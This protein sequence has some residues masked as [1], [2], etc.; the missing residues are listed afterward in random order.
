MTLVLGRTASAT[1]TS[2]SSIDLPAIDLESG[3]V[4]LLFVILGDGAQVS[5]ITD[6][7]G[8]VW[9]SRVA[10]DLG[11]LLDTEEWYAI[12]PPP[13]PISGNVITINFSNTTSFVTAEA[14]GVSG[15]NLES[16]F[17]LTAPITGTS[18]P[19]TVSTSVAHTMVVGAY[20]H[21]ITATPAP[22][23]GFIQIAGSDYLGVEYRIFDSIQ[24]DLLVDETDGLEDITTG[25]VDVLLAVGDVVF[26]ESVTKINL[27]GT[28]QFLVADFEADNFPIVEFSSDDD[29]NVLNEGSAYI[30]ETDFGDPTTRYRVTAIRPKISGDSVMFT[31]KDAEPLF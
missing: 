2:G 6:T 26:P 21:S 11:G 18:M 28:I 5:S 29:G 10:V 15:V 7:A 17:G 27:T 13:S 14:F 30:Y 9:S 12:A 24:N 4:V 3:T 25:I 20:R 1:A 16:V 8:L 23:A 19:L 31:L 22:G